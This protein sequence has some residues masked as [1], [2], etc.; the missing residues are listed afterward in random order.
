M[1]VTLRAGLAVAVALV[2]AAAVGAGLVMIGS[3]GEARL[4]RFDERRVADLRQISRSVALYWTVH[5]ALPES[6]AQLADLGGVTVPV[7]DPSTG[8]PYSYRVL[9]PARY[10]LCAVFDRAVE[11]LAP[12]ST[13]EFWSHSEGRQCFEL[14]P[15]ESGR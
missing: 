11:E 9:D 12:R 5:E 8:A 15:T 7:G 1:T 6:L 4:R 14:A 3:P 13:D 2:A 10:E